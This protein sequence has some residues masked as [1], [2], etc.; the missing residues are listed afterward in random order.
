M[1]SPKRRALVAVAA[2][3]QSGGDA[4]V[5]ADRHSGGDALAAAGEVYHMAAVVEEEDYRLA[6]AVFR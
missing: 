2:D 3:R 1:K 5:A 6:V 4:L